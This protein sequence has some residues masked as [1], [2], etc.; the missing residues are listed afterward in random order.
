MVGVD[1]RARPGAARGD[2]GE[3]P[4]G[5][6]LRRVRVE[7]VRPPL[8]DDLAQGEDRG[9]VG[10][11][12]E[13][14]LQHGQPE[15]ADAELVGDV[16]HRLL[17]GGQRSRDDDDVVPAARL[18]VGELEHVECRSADVQARD[19]VHDREA[20]V[21]GSGSTATGRRDAERQPEQRR[22]RRAAEERRAG[23][24]AGDHRKPTQR[25]VGLLAPRLA[26]PR[27][28]GPRRPRRGSPARRAR[29]RA[30]LRRGRARRAPD[31]TSAAGSTC[32]S[33]AGSSAAV[34]RRSARARP[35]RY[36]A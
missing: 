5:A 26:R 2:G 36:C 1:D 24:R 3:P 16:L 14:T 30:R 17:A 31:R 4:G 32:L 29:R 23:D 34:G 35:A 22:Q 27:L 33:P 21:G 11:R 19:H 20:H 18:L 8:P 9:G 28:G 7:D 10:A 25:H 6:G 13:L 15:Q 12:R